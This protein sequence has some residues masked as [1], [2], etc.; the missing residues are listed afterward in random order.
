MKSS[1]R[2]TVMTAKGIPTLHKGV[3]R[4]LVDRA[5]NPYQKPAPVEGARIWKVSLGRPSEP[6][7]VERCVAN[8]E[9]AI[10]WFDD[11]DLADF[12]REGIASLFGE[13]AGG[14]TPVNS[15]NS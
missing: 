14:A 11:Q 6:W 4:R 1:S 12:D 15:I 10:G 2:A 8:G 5:V 3:F 9:I 13:R 7:F